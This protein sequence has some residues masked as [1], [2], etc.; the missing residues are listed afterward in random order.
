MDNDF[1]IPVFD[2]GKTLLT[3]F[4]GYPIRYCNHNDEPHFAIVDVL[5]ALE[6]SESNDEYA[7]NRYWGGLKARISKRESGPEWL[8]DNIVR[9]KMTGRDGKKYPADATSTETLLRIVQSV[10]AAKAEPFKQW[11]AKVGYERLREEQNPSLAIDRAIETYRSQGRDEAWIFTRLQGKG[12]RLNLTGQWKKGGIVGPE[13]GYLTN[14][15]HENAFG[16]SVSAH[17]QRKGLSKSSHNLRDNMSR[18]ELGITLVAE[19]ATA[20]IAETRN[21]KG[22]QQ[23]ESA[24]IDGGGVAAKAR[25]E[26]EGHGVQ[27]VSEQNFLE[28]PRRRASIQP[29]DL[30]KG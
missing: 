3:E 12:A 21:A 24:A 22:Y 1:P 17:Y 19:E 4:N 16:L 11:L 20:Q 30:P 29:P 9:L 28:P 18:M 6:T 10:S 8:R 7:S 27:V 23:N 25:Q 5:L 15:V 2:G 13:Y 14:T 26:L